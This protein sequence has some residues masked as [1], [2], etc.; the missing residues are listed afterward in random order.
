VKRFKPGFRAAFDLNYFTGGNQTIAGDELIDVRQNSSF[1]ATLVLPFKGRHAIK[2]GFATGI[3]IEFGGDFDQFLV[4]YQM[5]LNERAAG[6]WPLD[7]IRLLRSPCL[8][9]AAR[10]RGRR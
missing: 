10:R 4:S 1:G 2:L 7:A 9:C 8:L 3:F 6:V 5:L